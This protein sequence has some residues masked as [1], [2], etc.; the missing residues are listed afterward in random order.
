MSLDL[1]QTVALAGVVLFA[2][3]FIRRIITPLGDHNIPAP[4]VG[5]LLVALLLTLN[6]AYF[7]YRSSSTPRCRR[8]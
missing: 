1:V 6:R 3:Y 7:E 4:V 8:R 5:G 2:G